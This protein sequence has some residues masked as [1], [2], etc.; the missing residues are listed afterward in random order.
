MLF[1]SWISSQSYLLDVQWIIKNVFNFARLMKLIVH[2]LN[3]IDWLT[4][5]CP[6]MLLNMFNVLIVVSLPHNYLWPNK[7]II[8]RHGCWHWGILRCHVAF[9]VCRIPSEALSWFSL[10]LLWCNLVSAVLRQVIKRTKSSFP[11]NWTKQCEV[12]FNL[13]LVNSVRVDAKFVRKWHQKIF[14]SILESFAYWV[15][16]FWLKK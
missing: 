11:L 2:L 3:V 10:L 9:I 7:S 13:C 4:L 1:S 15:T 8:S 5:C 6:V 16:V 12:I 14:L